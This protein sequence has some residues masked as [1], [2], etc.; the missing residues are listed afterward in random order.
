MNIRS[1]LDTGMLV[2]YKNVEY[3]IIGIKGDTL[4]LDNG[5]NVFDINKFDRDLKI[6]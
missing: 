5:V 4:T 3:R 6:F 2:K 1:Y